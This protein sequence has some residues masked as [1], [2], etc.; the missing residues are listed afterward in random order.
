[1]AVVDSDYNFIFV[2]I[3]VYGKECDSSVFKE[4][5]FWHKLT[6]NTLNLPDATRL[7]GTDYD[8]LFVFV[9]DEAFALHYHLLRPFG[10]H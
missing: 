9:G 2:D 4:T 10:G 3:G 7:P 1:M 8:L 6:N 5:T